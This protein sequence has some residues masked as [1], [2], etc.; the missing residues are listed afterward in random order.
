MFEPSQSS[1]IKYKKIYDAQVR[2]KNLISVYKLDLITHMSYSAGQA[3][4]SG[5]TLSRGC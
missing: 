3:R 5:V 1:P 2:E 4:W